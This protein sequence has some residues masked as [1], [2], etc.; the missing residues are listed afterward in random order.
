MS[1]WCRCTGWFAPCE[2]SCILR[3]VAGGCYLA[4]DGDRVP[5]TAGVIFSIAQISLMMMMIIA[6]TQSI[7]KLEPPNF[8]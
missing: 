8:A 2:C 5:V 1:P 6:V 3:G 4:P 7:F